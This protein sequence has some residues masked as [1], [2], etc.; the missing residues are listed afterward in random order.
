M[1]AYKISCEQDDYHGQ[2]VVF[3]DRM[4][5]IDKRAN[6]GNCDCEWI[7]IR[8]R[9]APEFDKY[10]PGPVTIDQY[11]DEGWHWEC[12]GCS[13]LVYRDDDPVIVDSY[14]YHGIECVKRDRD[15]WQRRE[16]EKWHES[17]EEL[18]SALDAFL[19]SV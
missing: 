11:L 12:S 2:L 8:V 13:Q 16:G 14:V 9:R 15:R 18:V 5:D 3:A 1:K 10:A 17:A 7:D 6:S 4:K 19:A